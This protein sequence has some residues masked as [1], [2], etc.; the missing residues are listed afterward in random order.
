MA[1]NFLSTFIAATEAQDALTRA[2][3][4]RM[5]FD[6]YLLLEAAIRQA[7]PHHENPRVYMMTTVLGEPARI[8]YLCGTNDSREHILVE[9]LGL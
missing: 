3:A 6:H 2:H 7:R 1:T 9:S 8:S 5:Y 4:R